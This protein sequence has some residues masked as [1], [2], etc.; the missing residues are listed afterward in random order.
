M[1]ADTSRNNALARILLAEDYDDLRDMISELLRGQNHIV[2][3]CE[4]GLDAQKS[5]QE[6]AFDLVI[7]DWELPKLTGIDVLKKYR[8]IGGT[9]PVLM[10]TGKRKLTDKEEGLDAGADDY[11]TKP[12]HP[13]ELTARIRALLRRAA[14]VPKSLPSVELE[15]GSTFA[16]RYQI[17]GMV[18]KGSSG[19]IYKARHMYL[20]R[21]V[22]L[23][24][25]HPQLMADEEALER[26]K[27]EAQALSKLDHPNVIKVHDFGITTQRLPFLVMDYSPGETLGRRVALEDHL[28]PEF[29]LPIFIQVCNGLA[30]AHERGI[31]HRDVKPN[32]LLLVEGKDGKP[33]VMLADFGIAKIPQGGEAT[34]VTQKGDVIGSPAYMSP[35]QCMGHELDPRTDIYSLGCVMY[36]ALMGRDVFEGGNVLDT[37]YR[38]TV[39]DPE[40]FASARPHIFCPPAVEAVVMKALSRDKTKRYQSMPDL[41]EALREALLE[42]TQ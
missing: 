13:Q 26:F 42:M 35:E 19:V 6:K 20:E 32:N 11:L 40:S 9:T 23:K 39:E 37:M 27:R 31:I 12:F 34:Q 5:I 29:A 18:G 16:E 7:L 21:L 15:D 8:A 30:Q 1:A 38:R 33:H 25:L 4:N 14:L 17:L 10:L 41:E 22:A 28:K 36:M 3:A 24:I 2:E